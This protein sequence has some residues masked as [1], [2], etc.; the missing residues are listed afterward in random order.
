MK[1]ANIS[2]VIGITNIATKAIG[3]SKVYIFRKKKLGKHWQIN[4]KPV[5]FHESEKN[6]PIEF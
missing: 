2:R 5:C 6:N 3:I 1:N 4:G